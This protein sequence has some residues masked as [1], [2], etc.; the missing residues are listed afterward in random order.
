MITIFVRYY[1]YKCETL[2]NSNFFNVI[3]HNY[4][5]DS[6]CFLHQCRCTRFMKLV[7]SSCSSSMFST[8]FIFYLI[9]LL[10]INQ[11]RDKPTEHFRVRWLWQYT[12]KRPSL[13]A[14]KPGIIL[15]VFS[16][17][18]SSWPAFFYFSEHWTIPLKNAS[19][20]IMKK[21]NFRWSIWLYKL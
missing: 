13:K 10:W 16:F 7:I 14:G 6:S 2:C 8:I 20:E 4:I 21:L 1:G 15:W 12:F 17:R 9:L 19:L 18:I 5:T 3:I 11:Q